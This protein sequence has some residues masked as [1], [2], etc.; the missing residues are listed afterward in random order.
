LTYRQLKAQVAKQ[1]RTIFTL[2]QENEKL[3]QGIAPVTTGEPS[4]AMVTNLTKIRQ[5]NS[6]LRK[7]AKNL[8]EKL[9]LAYDRITKITRGPATEDKRKKLLGIANSMKE[10][11]NHIV[12]LTQDKMEI[13]DTLRETLDQKRELEKKQVKLKKKERSSK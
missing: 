3:R 4:A 6:E 12:E 2:T 13:K 1:K 11:Q 10:M 7:Y 8:I 5:T 9:K